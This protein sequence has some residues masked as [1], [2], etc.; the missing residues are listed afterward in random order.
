MTTAAASGID[1]DG[2][3]IATGAVTWSS[4]SSAIAGINPTT[5]FIFAISPGTTRITAMVDGKVGERTVTVARAPAIRINE[6]QPRADQPTGWIEFFNPTS[7][8]V[9]LTEWSLIDANFFGPTFRFPAGSVIPA[10]G[11]LVIEE[12]ALPF[13]LDAIDSAYLFSRF[14]VL[15]DGTIWDRQPPTTFGRCD[16]AP[17]VLVVMTAP[18]KG[19]AN[20]CPEAGQAL[21]A[22]QRSGTIEAAR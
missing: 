7:A 5:G 13:G 1:Q 10:G 19:K 22:R 6:V 21:G 20:A 16:D 17:G 8:A 14:G 11:L 4:E 12:A 3:P 2:A 18:T 15:V 9:D